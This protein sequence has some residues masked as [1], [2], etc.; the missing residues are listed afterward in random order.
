MPLYKSKP[1]DNNTS[2]A[3]VTCD[4]SGGW[5]CGA[6][7]FRWSEDCGVVEQHVSVQPCQRRSLG[8]RL[9]MAWRVLR[10]GAMPSDEYILDVATA[11]NL[12]DWLREVKYDPERE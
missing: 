2:E 7:H 12:A 11:H 9:R 6:I 8:Y 3:I 5:R 4:C 1:I 10:Y